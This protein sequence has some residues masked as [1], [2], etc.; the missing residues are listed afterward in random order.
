MTRVDL[1]QPEIFH[2]L[3]RTPEPSQPKRHPWKWVLLAVLLG[4]LLY[5]PGAK[6]SSPDKA[7]HL[8]VSYA[9]TVS[10]YGLFRRALTSVNRTDTLTSGERIGAALFAGS[11]SMLVG[12]SFEAVGNGDKEDLLYDAIGNAA[13]VGTI[14]MFEF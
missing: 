14:M 2:N 13:A 12:A 11:L 7:A 10:T 6:G 9:L 1:T 5:S 8:G 3:R 4:A